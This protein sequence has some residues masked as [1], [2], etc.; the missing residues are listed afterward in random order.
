MCALS[1]LVVNTITYSLTI[2]NP[3]R[4]K[5]WKKFFAG[6]AWQNCVGCVIIKIPVAWGVRDRLKSQLCKMPKINKTHGRPRGFALIAAF[7][8]SPSVR[9]PGGSIT[10]A[11]LVSGM[12]FD[13]LEPLK[14]PCVWLTLP[15]R[16][17]P[18]ACPRCGQSPHQSSVAEVRTL[19]DWTTRHTRESPSGFPSQCTGG[20]GSC[21]PE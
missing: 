20:W 15:E 12:G 5:N 14:E 13:R 11:A 18:S 8:S 10:R 1:F 19:A 7:D 6:F 9:T 21:R 3:F 16:S 4:E 2:V 17:K